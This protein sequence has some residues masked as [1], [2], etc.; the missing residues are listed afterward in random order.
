MSNAVTFKGQGEGGGQKKE[1]K[2]IKKKR[3]K[4]KAKEARALSTSELHLWKTTC[5]SHDIYS[6]TYHVR[7]S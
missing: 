3:K 6:N 7:N 5:G 2:E 4:K 1:R